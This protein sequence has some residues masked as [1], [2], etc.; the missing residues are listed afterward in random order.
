V[1]TLPGY[2]IQKI[3]V[4]ICDRCNEDIT[5]PQ[6]GEDVTTLAEAHQLIRDHQEVWHAA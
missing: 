5:R 4:I 1:K 6:G 2:T 3:Y